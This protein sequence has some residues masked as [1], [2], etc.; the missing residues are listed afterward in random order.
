MS[1]IQPNST[2][3][4]EQS[5]YTT[6]LSTVSASS[7]SVARNTSALDPEMTYEIV[8]GILAIVLAIATLI[9]A[10]IHFRKSTRKQDGSQNIAFYELEIRQYR[11]SSSM[12]RAPELLH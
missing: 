5:T 1:P 4:V 7:S 6:D 3:I 8:F 10:V 2:A 11:R 12:P 9:I